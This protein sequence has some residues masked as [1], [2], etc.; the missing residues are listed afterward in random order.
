MVGSVDF[1]RGMEG[2][3]EFRYLKE[4]IKMLGG[5]ALSKMFEIVIM[6]GLQFGVMTRSRI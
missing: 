4:R 2:L 3:I 1:S 6:W 5:D